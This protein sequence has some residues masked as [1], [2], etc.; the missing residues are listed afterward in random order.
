M[1]KRLFSILAIATLTT[2]TWADISTEQLN[3]YMKA[4]GTDVVL[5]KMQTQLATSI[6]MKAKMRGQ[7][8]PADVL[9]EINTIASNKNN[10]ELIR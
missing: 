7:E 3:T 6:E 2:T 5:E 8:I 4:S 9:K 10:L 1:K